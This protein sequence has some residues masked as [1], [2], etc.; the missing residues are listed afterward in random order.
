MKNKSKYKHIVKYGEKNLRHCKTCCYSCQ[1]LCFAYQIQ[2]QTKSCINQVFATIPITTLD[3]HVLICKSYERKIK[4]GKLFYSNPHN[5]I[6]QNKPNM[7][8]VSM[9]NNIEE[10]F[11]TPCLT[12]T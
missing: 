8:F 9:L 2:Y 1:K 3:D 6:I 11:I 5:D 10:R 4:H 7:N 12:F